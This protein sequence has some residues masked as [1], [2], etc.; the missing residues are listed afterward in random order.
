[1]EEG[2]VKREYRFQGFY[3]TMYYILENDLLQSLT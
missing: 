3:Y 2:L 1:M